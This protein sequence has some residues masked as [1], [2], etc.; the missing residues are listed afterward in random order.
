MSQNSQKTRSRILACAAQEFLENGFINANLRR[1]A[2]AAQVTTGALY[3]HF[4]NKSE[5]FDALVA[6]PAEEMLARFRKIH[7]DV[8]ETL[9]GLTPAGMRK[10]ANTGT[11]WMLA[12]IYAHMEAFRLIFCCS[13]GTRWAGYLEELIAVEEQSYRYYCDTLGKSGN[14]TEDLFLHMTA[15]SGFQ[16]FVELVSHNVP[17]EQAVAVMDNVKRYGMAGWIEILGLAP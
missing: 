2:K 4:A 7:E 12:Y 11:N 15:S 6:A 16:Y 5:L 14:R 9:P 13:E 3:N 17:Y 10:S 8:K 1:I